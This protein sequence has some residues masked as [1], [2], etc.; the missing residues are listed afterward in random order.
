MRRPFK[1]LI[2]FSCLI[3]ATLA[4]ISFFT[5]G[6]VR[7]FHIF[8]EAPPQDTASEIRHIV[9]DKN[10]F[11]YSGNGEDISFEGDT[12]TILRSGTYRLTGKLTEGR[13]KISCS[14]GTVH[15][16][17]SGI[18]VSS[19][20]GAVIESDFGSNLILEAEKNSVN[21]LSSGLSAS[22]YEHLPSACVIL[23]SG[24]EIVG[25]GKIIVES[26]G[27]CGI[28]SLL[29]LKLNITQLTVNAGS[30]GILVRDK[31]CMS[32]GRLTLKDVSVGICAGSGNMS[33]GRIN[34]SGGTLT[35]LCKETALSAE[36]EILITG[37]NAGIDSEEIYRCV[38]T[39][40]GKKIQGKITV[41]ASGFPKYNSDAN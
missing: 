40:N 16:I 39:E 41:S 34:I 18:T 23:R 6:R 2:L 12:L 7:P 28:L 14:D 21:I 11:S 15:L 38:R 5:R 31:F 25:E 10:S 30:V 35:A 13:I 29:D 1:I 4:A 22:R 8:S 20:Y 33:E 32:G 26:A 9:F 24:A 36:R 27:D 19:S 17:L 3:I 37:G